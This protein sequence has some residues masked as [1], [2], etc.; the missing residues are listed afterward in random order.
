MKTPE[1]NWVVE[2]KGV[3]D[4]FASFDQ[5]LYCRRGADTNGME[6]ARPR[7]AQVE[8]FTYRD[9]SDAT[10]AIKNGRARDDHGIL[11]EMVKESCVDLRQCMLQIFN[12]ILLDKAEAPEK[13]KR[14]KMVVI[15]KQGDVELPQNYRPIAILPILYKVFSR[16]LCTRMA[17]ELMKHQDVDQA[18]YRKGFSTEDHVI[19]VLSLIE[20]SH[21]FNLPLW[22]AMVDF[23]KAFDSIDHA[24][25]WKV[26]K[27][28][29]S[30]ETYINLLSAMY[31]GQMATVQA[32]AR[33]R[34]FF[35]ER[36]VKQGDPVSAL[37]FIA[38]MQDLCGRLKLKWSKANL[39][40][41]GAK[42]GVTLRAQWKLDGL[43]FRR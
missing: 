14:T 34:P 39:R 28:Q 12:N 41:K 31:E 11:A 30:T 3:A 16:M 43:A 35:I 15:F 18:A 27:K 2:Q 4:V 42:F 26:L 7:N 19:T 36:G 40:W 25:L 1:G 29:S 9:L 20:R 38:V 33:S 10:R 13:W 24:S 5:E 37:L 23:E 8:P 6:D 32:G 17:A 21:E 22:M